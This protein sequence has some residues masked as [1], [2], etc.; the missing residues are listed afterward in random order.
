MSGLAVWKGSTLV[1]TLSRARGGVRFG[2]ESSFL[3]AVGLGKPTISMGLPTSARGYPDRACRPFFDG[4][5][6]EGEARRII[7]YDFG[8]SSA[9]TFGML[10]IIGRD[11]AG[12]LAVLPA[13]E[14][15]PP[16]TSADELPVLAGESVDELIANLRIHPLG[17]DE[18]VRASLGGV[19]EKLL[20]TERSDGSWALPSRCCFSTW[21][22]C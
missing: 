12:A 17:V 2:F 18:A 14:S 15:L 9:D 5:L 3:E 16:L 19:Q 4:L 7:A 8:V 13:G 11:C 21:T 6:P 1:G 22:V 10:S 20:L